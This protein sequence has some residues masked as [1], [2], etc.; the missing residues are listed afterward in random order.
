MN[1]AGPNFASSK[2][3]D[4]KTTVNYFNQAVTLVNKSQF[5]PVIDGCA[6]YMVTN[7]GDTIVRVNDMTL[8][9]SATPTTSAGDSKS[10]ALHKGDIYK[11]VLRIAFEPG[12]AA[13]LLEVVQVHYMED[14][15][16]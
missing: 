14:F 6:G 15:K 13:P 2:S 3:R 10:I 9:P 16:D 4:G 12:G 1:N 5:M 8:F 11:G 7:L